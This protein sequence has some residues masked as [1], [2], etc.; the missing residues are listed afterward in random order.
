[1]ASKTLF[2][3]KKA[4]KAE[5]FKA[6]PTELKNEAGGKTYKREDREALAQLVMTG[7]LGDVF[8]T[9]G[10]EQLNQVLDLAKRVD[11]E[12]L[13]K[14]AVEARENGYMKDTPA[15]ICAIL[16]TRGEEGRVFL[17][18]IFNRVIDNGKMLRNF[19]QIVR[20]G[21]VG[22]KS[23][24]SA[25]KNLVRDWFRNR[26]EASIFRNSVGN[27]PSMADVIK[28]VHPKPED[29]TREALYAYILGKETKSDNLP[30]VVK[31][32]ERIKASKDLTGYNEQNGF[33][34]IPMEMLAGLEGLSED[35]WKVLATN[36][37]WTQLRMNLNT[38]ARH[39]VLKSEKMVNLI[40]DKL[41]DAEAI[42]KAK[43]Y[44]YQIFTSLMFIGDDVPNK[45]QRALEDALDM[46]LDNIPDLEGKR[47]FVFPDVSGSMSSFVT[48]NRGTASTKMRYV[49]VAAL[50]AAALRRKGAEVWAVDTSLHKLKIGAKAS[51]AEVAKT[52][53]SMGGGG[54]NLSLPMRELNNIGEKPDLI[55]YFSDNESWADRG[56]HYYGGT[57]MMQEFEKLKKRAPQCKLVCVDMAPYQ[58]KQA[59]ESK[60]ILNVGGF[61]DRV[62]DVVDDFLKG[63][64]G[65]GFWVSQIEKV[66]V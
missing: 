39:G 36:M 60:D 49:D 64:N 52:L 27:D 61:S 35:S 13:A 7:F 23:L 4:P 28:M 26:N 33:N 12:F 47:V 41:R 29:K 44:P 2:S 9:T 46:S 51:V 17:R 62:F 19:V 34:A 10:Q 31:V 15:L 8:Y 11:T 63:R 43:V 21:Q 58:G 20:S 57:G 22:R 38:L 66:E 54:T 32:F 18:K 42:K 14:L 3:S 5:P 25:P 48:G 40:A 30:E 24:G 50:F 6:Q 65:S 53:A 59:Q 1:M 37:S 56:M 55:V 16:T 45:I